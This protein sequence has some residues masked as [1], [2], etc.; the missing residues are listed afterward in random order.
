MGTAGTAGAGFGGA[1]TGGGGGSGTSGEGGAGA[2]G[3]AGAA[4]SAG[5]GAAGASGIA[6]AAGIGGGGGDTQ[7]GAAGTAGTGGC[8]AT[9]SLAGE[10]C[11]TVGILQ[12][13]SDDSA[14]VKCATVQGC[15][16]WTATDD[17]ATD[18]LECSGS[19]IQCVCPVNVTPTDLYANP[20]VD[21]LKRPMLVTTGVRTPA[22][23]SYPTIETALAVAKAQ[24]P[25]AAVRVIASADGPPPGWDGVARF[26]NETF[27]LVIPSHVLITTTDDGTLGGSG[28]VP[29][30]WVIQVDDHDG[31][32]GKQVLGSIV[33]AGS[34][35]R[36]SPGT[37]DPGGI[38]RGVSVVEATCGG[39]CTVA[40]SA[41]R[42][43]GFSDQKL[44]RLD[45]V[46]V[47]AAGSSAFARGISVLGNATLQDVV[48]E[49][50]T[51]ASNDGVGLD[52]EDDFG[53]ESS[54]D[55]VDVTG[56]TFTAN[57]T[58]IA[59]RGGLVSI[60]ASVTGGPDPSIA[61]S[62]KRGLVSSTS[63]QATAK[64]TA[65]TVTGSG[66]EGILMSGTGAFACEG[67]TVG[68]N[69]KSGVFVENALGSV[70]LVS[71]IVSGNGAANLVG[72]RDGVR[73]RGRLTAKLVLITQ[74][75]GAGVVVDEAD[76]SGTTLISGCE[77]SE[78]TLDGVQVLSAPYAFDGDDSAAGEDVDSFDPV[79]DYGFTIR[80][81]L[82]VLPSIHHNLGRGIAV[83]SATQSAWIFAGIF[84]SEVY[85]N[86]L[87]G[88]V[89]QQKKGPLGPSDDCDPTDGCT[90]VTL[91]GNRLYR[92]AGSGLVLGTSFLKP[93][94]G[95]NS[96]EVS[97]NVIAHN[98]Q[99]DATCSGQVAPQVSI[100][101]PVGY[102]SGPCFSAKNEPDCAAQNVP[103][104]SSNGDDNR[105]V[106][107][108]GKCFVSFRLSGNCA[109][110]AFNRI[111]AYEGSGPIA[112]GLRASGGAVVAAD[113][114]Q[115]GFA[116]M[117]SNV[118]VDS[119][120]FVLT[121]PPCTPDTACS[122]SVP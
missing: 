118:S 36:P 17:C 39:P 80:S 107:T 52:I 63:A 82:N 120:S 25:A 22:L 114:T 47:V 119:S 43:E 57:G 122:F 97:N 54:T 61:G 110:T 99:P 79:Q 10:G 2:A 45:H 95:A 121:D 103:A 90:A 55:W 5:G 86:G 9:G 69:G 93:S 26:S 16:V 116:S 65:L 115:W 53:D 81:S 44:P 35:S 85:E 94:T 66:E 101:G 23:C 19:T 34:D 89:V 67:C 7:G 12:C 64:A 50:F 112:T 14:V 41:I 108:G 83:G 76:A 18:G 46:S 62:T 71:G 75:H 73:V 20:V 59:L 91:R 58:G 98:A 68:E 32:P 38:V 87:E 70:D 106:W 48:V 6:G 84:D 74:N 51:G 15:D 111:V 42:I 104:T 92:N 1:G 33:L 3:V 13:A 4:G 28:F 96:R 77:I 60:R 40:D 56:G 37:A 27:P 11:S 29:G 30:N 8:P 109:S 49:S 105:C 88:V 21:R 113:N 100:T 102:K 31:D 24:L 78:N 72:N 117:T